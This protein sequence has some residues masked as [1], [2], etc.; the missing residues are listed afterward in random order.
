MNNYIIDDRMI[1]CE[2]Q[3]GDLIWQLDSHNMTD[4]EIDFI[5]RYT[6]LESVRE[7]HPL[8]ENRLSFTA[9]SE[10]ALRFYLAEFNFRVALKNTPLLYEEQLAIRSAARS[11]AQNWEG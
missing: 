11:A 7:E 1:F 2:N 5:D 3:D 10:A 9:N 6:E 8:L 4:D